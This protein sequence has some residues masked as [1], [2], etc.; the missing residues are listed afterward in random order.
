M[1]M[2][3]PDRQNFH[4]HPLLK[5][6]DT[7]R[8]HFHCLCFSFSRSTKF[9]FY[10]SFRSVLSS[11]IVE[12]PLVV[13]FYPHTVDRLIFACQL[14][15]KLTLSNHFNQKTAPL[16]LNDILIESK[17]L[18]KQYLRERS[19]KRGSKRITAENHTLIRKN[20]S[21]NFLQTDLFNRA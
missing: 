17:V 11:C 5:N 6:R 20:S 8:G 21:F 16:A 7:K 2:P 12:K 1:R 3:F 10:A 13:C 9:E 14:I 4:C 18:S 19:E 15:A